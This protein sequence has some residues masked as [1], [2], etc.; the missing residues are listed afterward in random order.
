MIYYQNNKNKNNIK[1]IYLLFLFP[2]SCDSLL[3]VLSTPFNIFFSFSPFSLTPHPSFLSHFLPSFLFGSF[4]PS[5]SEE[6]LVVPEIENE[7]ASFPETMER[8]RKYLTHVVWR[9]WLHPIVCR[10]VVSRVCERKGRDSTWRVQGN[11]RHTKEKRNWRL[12]KGEAIEQLTLISSVVLSVVLI[13]F[14]AE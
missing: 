4:L 13:L 10:I 2:L 12:G 1:T 5:F 14:V 11:Y 6:S 8:Q 7:R 9:G 3:C